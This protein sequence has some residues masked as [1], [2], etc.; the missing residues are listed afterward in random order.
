[1]LDFFFFTGASHVVMV[2]E[3]EHFC[4]LFCLDCCKLN[5]NTLWFP[6]ESLSRVV[7]VVS[8]TCNTS[9][10]EEKKREKKSS[11]AVQSGCVPSV[12]LHTICSRL[13]T[14]PIVFKAVINS[15][16]RR[17]W[18]TITVHQT[19]VSKVCW[20]EMQH[21][22]GCR[23]AN[24]DLLEVEGIGLKVFFLNQHTHASKK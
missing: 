6:F 4:P 10:W 11:S 18:S 5:N 19:K 8:K 7:L 2:S 3:S 1:M 22:A 23:I 13:D 14:G 15:L 9:C 24:V 17:R 12:H 16:C 20:L 21:R